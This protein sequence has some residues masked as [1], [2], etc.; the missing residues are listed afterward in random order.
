MSYNFALVIVLLLL[1]MRYNIVRFSSRR[2]QINKKI[3][4]PPRS[5]ALPDPTTMKYF[6]APNNS[7]PVTGRMARQ[8]SDRIDLSYIIDAKE[9]SMP[10]VEQQCKRVALDYI[11]TNK[12]T[13]N[14]MT[15]AYNTYDWKDKGWWLW[16]DEEEVNAACFLYPRIATEALIFPPKELAK[17]LA[18]SMYWR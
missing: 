2:I 18:N 16:Y 12:L 11:R 15:L 5:V 13:N 4:I 17:P 1:I 14:D 3:T 6:G 10:I 7:T 8:S 9:S